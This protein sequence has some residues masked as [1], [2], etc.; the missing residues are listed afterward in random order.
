[1]EE[2]MK[3]QTKRLFLLALVF[4]FFTAPLLTGAQ[5]D[6][7][8]EYKLGRLSRIAS[9]KG[10]VRVIVELDVPNIDK[11]S[12]MSSHFKTGMHDKYLKQNALNADLELS[13][14][15]SAVRMDVLRQLNGTLYRVN[16]SY[17]FFPLVALSLTTESLEKLKDIPAVT[18][19][20]ED[21][22]IPL[23][24]AM[25][26]EENN[27][28]VSSPQLTDSTVVV[29]AERAWGQ[30]YDGSGWYVAILDTGAPMAWKKWADPVRLLIM[31]PALDM[32][33]M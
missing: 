20:F 27:G 26:F 4:L 11:L 21:V 10:H 17:D 2:K 13:Q 7:Y 18:T 24:E 14:A 28:N 6:N 5:Y 1:M 23:P 22:A 32:A 9:E 29:G 33:A 30:G 8:D 25:S 3:L 31:R 12:R 15:I 16:R 19:I